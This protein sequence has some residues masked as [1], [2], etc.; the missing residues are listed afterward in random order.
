MLIRV[1]TEGNSEADALSTY[2]ILSFVCLLFV[3]FL[4]DFRKGGS[5]VQRWDSDRG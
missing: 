5:K 3:C 4:F 2:H 1:K